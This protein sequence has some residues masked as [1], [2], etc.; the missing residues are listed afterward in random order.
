M[1][2]PA[3]LQK[4]AAAMKTLK[5]VHGGRDQLVLD[6]LLVGR[7]KKRLHTSLPSINPVQA[8]ETIPLDSLDHNDSL[9]S[10]SIT[11]L[12]PAPSSTALPDQPSTLSTA[13]IDP[14]RHHRDITTLSTRTNL[15]YMKVTDDGLLRLNP[16]LHDHPTITQIILTGAHLTDI[17]VMPF[18]RE[19]LPSLTRLVYLDL[20]CNAITNIG[21]IN[22]AQS[23]PQCQTLRVLSLAGNRIGFD[24]IRVMAMAVAGAH[25]EGHSHSLEWVSLRNN[26][27]WIPQDIEAV[28]KIME[29]YDYEQLVQEEVDKD[30][31]ILRNLGVF[32]VN[33]RALQGAHRQC[34]D[35]DGNEGIE[36]KAEQTVNDHEALKKGTEI[37]EDSDKDSSRDSYKEEKEDNKPEGSDRLRRSPSPFPVILF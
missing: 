25:H 24:G 28:M 18:A 21:A 35:V 34:L 26:H 32:S 13:T 33:A 12:Q 36:S 5:I 6:A 1:H 7:P 9:A 17:S 11:P 3:L 16:A 30:G 19:V 10:S 14:H 22:I 27:L 8:P 2:L 37:E 31:G 15:K 29:E 20:S 4:S 23:L